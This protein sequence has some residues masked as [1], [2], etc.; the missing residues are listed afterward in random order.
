MIWSNLTG[1]KWEPTTNSEASSNCN[2]ADPQTPIVGVY[3]C[4]LGSRKFPDEH[5]IS[6][7]LSRFSP[8]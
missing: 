8:R 6:A 7:Y 2:P 5:R 4:L 3:R 1:N